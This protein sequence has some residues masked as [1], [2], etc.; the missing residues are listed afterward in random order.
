MDSEL[1]LD[2]LVVVEVVSVVPCELEL[3]L[4]PV[5]DEVVVVELVVAEGSVELVVDEG[6][7]E[8]VVDEGVVELVVV[9]SSVDTE[10]TVVEV[11][12]VVEVAVVVFPNSS[13]LY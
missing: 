3:E 5:V 12:W 7:V 4:E 1:A 6:A 13:S 11:V 8:L 2:E 10:D 9:C